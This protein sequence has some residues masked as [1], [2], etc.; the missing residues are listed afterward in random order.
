MKESGV[1]RIR[2][3]A[4]P[5]WSDTMRRYSWERL[6]R[7]GFE[8]LT[9]KGVPE[10]H[11]RYLAEVAVESEAM[12]IETHGVAAFPY[13]DEQIVDTLNRTARRIGIATL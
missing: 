12:G 5:G 9:A 3:P 1:G 11:A 7:F 6:V 10:E 8:L 4:E 13:F 2:P